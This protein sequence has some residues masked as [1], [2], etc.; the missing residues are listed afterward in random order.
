[1]LS[2]SRNTQCTKSNKYNFETTIQYKRKQ[3]DKKALHLKLL[4][5]KIEQHEPH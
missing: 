5:I 2:A 1:M 3:K 4:S